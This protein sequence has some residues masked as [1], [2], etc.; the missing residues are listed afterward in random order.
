METLLSKQGPLAHVWLAAN[1]DRKLSKQQL[2]STNI[3]KTS[4]F[5][6]GDQNSQ[7]GQVIDGTITLRL[8]GQLLLG[9]V[10]IYSRK[11]KYLL[12]DVNDILYKL[13]N[14]FRV[15]NGLT[16]G[17]SSNGSVSHGSSNSGNL[18]AILLP[19]QQTMISSVNQ[20]TL[21]DQVTNFD[22][23]YQEELNLD[24]PREESPVDSGNLSLVDQSFN[25]NQSIE[26]PR[27]GV[28]RL[29]DEDDGVDVDFDLNFDLDMDNGADA[30]SEADKSIEVG[31][32]T[33][34]SNENPDLSIN[35]KGLDDLD[36]GFDE[37]LETVDQVRESENQ[38]GEDEQQQQQES[39]GASVIAEPSRPKRKLVGITEEGQ[40]KTVKRRLIVDS[41]SEVETGIPIQELRSIQNLQLN[42][43][44]FITLT[45]SEDEKLQLINE[46][47]EPTHL[48]NKSLWEINQQLQSRCMEIAEI[49]D[50]VSAPE[51]PLEFDQSLDF[52]LDL[53]DL[54]SDK[55]Q[56][57]VETDEVQE[58]VVE[59]DF[60]EKTKSTIQIANHL[61]ETFISGDE[62]TTLSNIIETDLKL[63]S[64]NNS[65]PLGITS[66]NQINGKREAT[67]CFFELLVL[68]TN[69]CITINQDGLE[70]TEIGG[71]IN[72][73]PR[74]KIYTSF[75]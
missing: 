62:V 22:L 74:D 21:Q 48:R 23:L 73:R 58:T 38:E 2:L 69:D 54:E 44:N 46:L 70:S 12:E 68:A 13:K 66:D 71:K 5:I 35:M 72:I 10:R 24:E 43:S 9:I 33:Q 51:S 39:E 55:E 42:G 61:R 56:P 27:S 19:A 52:D 49:D 11:T 29:H 31:R 34:V 65:K 41:L 25:F 63:S 40:L 57:E 53:P 8:S 32:N 26:Y 4:K 36:F 14:S 15:V 60:N 3:V 50:N 37:P 30:N 18:R 6:S 47:S 64:D 20:I 7:G 75:L 28:S 67:K 45:L 16:G 59:E 17:V 1:Y